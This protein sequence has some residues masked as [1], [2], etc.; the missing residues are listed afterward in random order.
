MFLELDGTFWVQLIN[1]VIFFLIVRVVFLNPVGAAI[2]KRRA[3]IDGVQADFKKYSDEARAVRADA[4]AHRAAARREAEELVARSRSDS[5]KEAQGIGNDYGA[6]ASEIADDARKTVEG[7]VAA[8][9]A[10]EPELADSLAR[11]LLDR[12]VGALGG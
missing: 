2:R 5:E 12:A 3:Y 4:E 9:R 1:F 6:R 7:E 8:A 10:K 11:T